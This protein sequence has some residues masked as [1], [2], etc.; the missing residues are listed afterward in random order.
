M[1]EQE[2]IE[3]TEQALNTFRKDPSSVSELL[4]TYRTAM[5]N[6]RTNKQAIK[7]ITNLLES[8]PE[9]KSKP[10]YMIRESMNK[11]AEKELQKYLKNP[12]KYNKFRSGK[13]LKDV[14]DT[15]LKDDEAYLIADATDEPD[16]LACK[17]FINT[18]D[19]KKMGR[20]AIMDEK[21][22]EIGMA[23]KYK[24]EDEETYFVIIFGKA[25]VIGGEKLKKTE[26]DLT[27]LKEAFDY[28]DYDKTGLISTVELEE[29]LEHLGFP[30]QEEGI[31]NIIKNMNQEK[32]D[33]VTFPTF[34]NFILN[35]VDNYDDDE[36]LKELFD[37]YKDDKENN[38]ISLSSLTELCK[39]LDETDSLNLCQD[40]QS[41]SDDKEIVLNYDQFLDYVHQHFSSN[42]N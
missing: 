18:E 30:K 15:K 19:I 37:I 21:I 17:L 22:V 31:F 16:K 41:I 10:E 33:K 12:K 11:I 20:K 13:D 9:M 3:S 39:Y 27:E 8:L 32:G 38:T 29:I 28:F 23:A 7:E 4:Q 40:L 35:I 2:F 24:K 25:G 26:V 6:M 1:K 14:V 34:A 42:K 36:S 5:E